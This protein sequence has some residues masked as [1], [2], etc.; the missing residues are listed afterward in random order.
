VE[1]HSTEELLKVLNDDKI[2]NEKK[3]I[4]GG[5]SN[6]LFTGDF[7]GVVILNRLVKIEKVSEDEDHVFITAGA[8]L[9]WHS[10]VL[11][12]VDHNYQGLENLSLIPGCVGAAPIQNIGAYGVEIRNT[13]QSLNAL[14]IEE[15]KIHQ[16]DNESCRFGYRDSIFKQEGKN[17]YCIL[18][19]TFCLNKKGKL[20]TSYGAIEDQLKLMNVSEPNLKDV[21]NA[22]IAIRKSKLPDPQVI[23]NAGSFF[24]NPEIPGEQFEKLV[25]E[26]PGLVGYPSGGKVKLAAGWLIE[27]CGWKGKRIGNVG[28]HEKQALVLV[29][30]GG[31]SGGELLA[32]AVSVRESVFKKF[33][34]ELEMEVNII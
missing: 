5:G 1:V 22:V 3:L 21:S 9:N 20:N 23:G 8:G 32:H 2:K 15:G 33:G 14:N 6:M 4:L 13:F 31:A 29:N 24:K 28:M 16:F 10:F 12:T 19:V 17:K 26:F 18:D 7:D 27:Q 30:Y 11:Y 34:V 25:K